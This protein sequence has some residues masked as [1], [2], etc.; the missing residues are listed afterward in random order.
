MR[1]SRLIIAVS[2]AS[3]ALFLL[4]A[5]LRAADRPERRELVKHEVLVAR[6]G[7]GPYGHIGP[8]GGCIPGGPYGAGNYYIPGPDYYPPK[9]YFGPRL[10]GPAPVGAA[11]PDYGP[12]YWGAR[13]YLVPAFP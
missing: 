4:V 11:P 7:C 6:H 5:P 2:S 9:P 1:G 13:D 12:W 10:Y 8:W 3:A